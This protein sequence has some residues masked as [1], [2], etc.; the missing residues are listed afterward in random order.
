M[1]RL[2]IQ[3]DRLLI[4]NL[5][6]PDLEDFHVY[7]ANPEVTLYQG[8]NVMDLE[9]ARS[10]IANQKDKLFG[11]PG[12]WVQYGL[13]NISTGKIIGDCAIKLQESDPRIAE[14]GL[15]VSHLE[16]QKGFAKEAFTGILKFLFGEENIHRVEETVDAE[17]M[18]SIRLLESM[19]FRQEGHF[20][21]NIFFNGKWGSEYQYAMLRREWLEK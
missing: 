20:I 7:R 12:E 13:E 21:E 1:K 6:L 16:Q 9:E 2:H 14:V 8:F 17:N 11:N 3:T 18:A 4:R 5:R 15:T 10:F 19:G